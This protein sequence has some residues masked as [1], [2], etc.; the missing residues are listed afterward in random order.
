MTGQIRRAPAI[1]AA[2][3]HPA[4]GRPDAQYSANESIRRHIIAGIILVAFL[5][6]GLGVG[7]RLP[8]SPAP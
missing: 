6:F 3:P 7:P 1:A 5:A 8:K 2:G 4:I